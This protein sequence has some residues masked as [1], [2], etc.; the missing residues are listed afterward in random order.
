MFA[1]ARASLSV[2]PLLLAL[3]VPMCTPRVRPTAPPW[4]A[5]M[6]ELWQKP[7]DLADRDL[8]YGPWGPKHAP[9][10]HAT[11]TF[12]APKRHGTNPG[13]V[14]T[15]QEGREWHIK[16]PPRNDQGAEGPNEVVL[17]RVLSA[18]GYHQPPIYFLPSFTVH[19]DAGTRTVPGGRFRLKVHSLSHAGEWSWQR[20]PFVGTYPYQGLLVTLLLFNSSDLKNVN[21]TV[22]ERKHPADGVDRWF[23]VRD[24]GTALG[25]T[26][27]LHPRRGDIDLF[28]RT[29]FITGVR[30]GFVEFEYHGWHRELIAERI[31]PADVAW[32]CELVGGLSRRQWL[33]A[34]RA[35]GYD[36]AVAERFV[37][38]ILARIDE[39]RRI[40]SDGARLTLRAPAR[41]RIGFATPAPAYGSAFGN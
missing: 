3:Y 29:R 33:D 38:R 8:Y 41:P 18:I 19:D 40:A 6:A 24:L 35:G 34:F 32:T 9:D 27:R 10:P 13:M 14:V 31:T 28:E 5:R 36:A 25:E 26:A 30:Q 7:L 12:V 22:Y 15:D 21:N 39:G 23:V 17:S 20:N 37:N 4:D 16:Q 1:P 11:Y 2:V